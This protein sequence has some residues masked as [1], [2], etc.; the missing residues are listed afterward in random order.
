[1]ADWLADL[2]N[3]LPAR[4]MV[5]R[6]WH[7]HFGTGLVRTPSDFGI[8]GDR[9]SHPE[10]LDWLADEYQ[11]NGWQLK[12]L[13]RLI[14]LSAAYR[15]G[16]RPDPRAAT[17]DADNR[18]LWR[19]VPRRLDAEV[20]RDTMLQVSGQLNREAGGPGYQ[21]WNTS[22]YVTV[23][24]P[25]TTLGPAEFRRM[26]YQFKPRTQQDPTFGVFD[27]PDATQAA[28]RRIASTT[29]LQA[30]NLLNDPFVHGQAAAFAERVRREAGL[31]PGDQVARAFRLA[32]GREPAAD[33]RTAA[34]NLINAP[35]LARL[36][37]ALFNANEFV[38]VD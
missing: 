30:L 38:F 36:C 4:V 24:Q 27:C 17:V 35:G 19:R 7:H 37:H 22:N 9:P 11:A 12:P 16:D 21:L 5:N 20:I 32:F 2:A 15:R 1:L 25:K 14:V 28:P 8:N 6:V 33:E 29:A 13:H 31:A 23:Y 3:P 10:L 26:V 34:I 18:L